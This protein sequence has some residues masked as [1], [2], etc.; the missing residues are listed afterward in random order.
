M[1]LVHDPALGGVTIIQPLAMA[2]VHCAWICDAWKW[3]AYGFE[4]LS[5]A[6]VKDNFPGVS[7]DRLSEVVDVIRGAKAPVPQ[8]CARRAF[9]IA[10]MTNVK[11]LA[12]LLGVKLPEDAIDLFGVLCHFIMQVSKWTEANRLEIIEIMSL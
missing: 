5:P 7:D 8:M 4:S 10:A 11:R 12:K 2:A 3:E 6:H 1:E 9:G